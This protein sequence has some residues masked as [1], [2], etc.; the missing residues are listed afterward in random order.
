[1]S[2]IPPTLQS[3]IDELARLPG[4]G[5]KSA[6]R[7]A[8]YLL[9][10]PR[11]KAENLAGAIMAVKDRLSLCRICHNIAE[12]EQCPIC[13]DPKRDASAI[14]VVE[15]PADI[16]T[17]EKSGAFHGLYHVLGGVLS[18]L[19]HQ[20]SEDLNV[21]DLVRRGK[22]GNVREVILATNPTTEGEATALLV[23]QM[24]KSTPAKVT[25]IARGVPVGS[26]L[27]FADEATLARALEGRGEL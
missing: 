17:L 23:A 12:D 24:L 21:N 18:P 27:E 10:A 20:N 5:K 1:M 2:S 3:L 26:D 19:D 15:Q 11:E 4:V 8:L 13:A 22:D 16:L 25:R 6:Q 14:C 7:M 9:K